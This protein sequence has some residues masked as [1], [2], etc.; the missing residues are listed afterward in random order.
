MAPPLFNKEAT[1]TNGAPWCPMGPIRAQQEKTN[2]KYYILFILSFSYVL[3][4]SIIGASSFVDKFRMKEVRTLA[5]SRPSAVSTAE[6]KVNVAHPRSAF[7]CMVLMLLN[8]D[9]GAG[10]PNRN[11]VQKK[12]L[13]K[14]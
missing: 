14:R 12:R 1:M 9:I 8:R 2:S 13:T 3:A 4:D 10:L 7:I 5:V 11:R 6:S